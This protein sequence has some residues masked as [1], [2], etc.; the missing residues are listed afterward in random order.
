MFRRSR[1]L[2]VLL[3]A[4]SSSSWMAERDAGKRKYGSE[5]GICMMCCSAME[6]RYDVSGGCDLVNNK[7]S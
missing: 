1:D 5:L 2:F 6:K 3:F 7:G 4:G